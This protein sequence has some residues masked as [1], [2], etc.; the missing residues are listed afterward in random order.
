MDMV[1]LLSVSAGFAGGA[2]AGFIAGGAVGLLRDVNMA[3]RVDSIE[4]RFK[5]L[6]NESIS[7]S[8]VDARTEKAE[9]QSE[10]MAYVMAR[11]QEKDAVPTLIL[12]EAALKY[13][14]VAASL[15]SKT[16]KGKGPLAGLLGGI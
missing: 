14:D 13:P 6:H 2:M 16:M 11:M 12:K 5:R 8:G 1:G 15:L 3:M 7:T 4:A 9:R 10:A